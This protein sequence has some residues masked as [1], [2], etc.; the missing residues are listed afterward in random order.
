MQSHHPDGTGLLLNLVYNPLGPSLPPNQQ[1]L[2]ADYQCEL[3]AHFGIVFNRLFT[4]ANMPIQCS[5]STLIS[6]GQFN[7]YMQLLKNSYSPATLAAVCSAG[8]FPLARFGC[9]AQA[10]RLLVLGGGPI[11]CELAQSFSRLGSEV[12]LVEMGS[13]LLASEDPE[14]SEQV[15]QALR[16]DGGHLYIGHIPHWATPINTWP[17]NGEKPTSLRR[18]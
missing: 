11:G 1:Q 16:A 2:E 4:L 12:T 9:Y 18:C 6:K 3:Q 14:V 5:G 7:D 13:R 8:V 10:A 15:E 17:A